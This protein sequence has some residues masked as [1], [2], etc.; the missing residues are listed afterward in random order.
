MSKT[1]DTLCL[2]ADTN[3]FAQCRAL[4]EL[5]WS[6]FGA[7]TE[8]RIIVSR[9][10]QEEIDNQKNSDRKRLAKRADVTAR[11]FRQ[12]IAGNNVST[13][14][15][16]GPP[17][18]TL[19][20]LPQI[21]PDPDIA[22]QLDY[23]KNDDRLV[24]IAHQYGRQN[25]SHDVA[26]LTHDTGPMLSANAVGLPYKIIPD[27]WFLPPEPSDV[28][29][30]ISALR[31]ENERLKRAEPQF[32]IECRVGS[33]DSATRLELV[34]RRAK[35]MSDAQIN[36]LLALLRQRHPMIADFGSMERAERPIHTPF[37]IAGFNERFEP[38]S[39]EDIEKYRS[40][41]YPDWITACE[42]RLRNWHVAMQKAIRAPLA[43]FAVAN[44]GSRPGTDALVTIATQGRF[45]IVVPRSSQ[46]DVEAENDD[47]SLSLP[48]VPMAPRG[49]WHQAVPGIGRD[50]RALS[51]DIRNC[52]PCVMKNCPLL[53]GHDCG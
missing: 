32:A 24:G 12:I 18:V 48:S 46:D 36:E 40:A 16:S 50:L 25:V 19:F 27:E 52:P 53:R 13:T 51:N 11:R 1:T 44:T 2:F 4:E 45:S 37:R 31:S 9:P 7:Y 20:L 28:D 43:G 3:L 34:A 35:A 47:A 41:T 30:Q 21:K 26:V 38:A 10:V 22:D 8:V 6:M 23:S 42:Q 39:D 33:S 15:L 17:L 49:A 29:R 5:D 14:L